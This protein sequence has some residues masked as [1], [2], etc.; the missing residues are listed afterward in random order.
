[1]EH[2]ENKP[3]DPFDAE[4]IP[5]LEDYHVNVMVGDKQTVFGLKA[6][7]PAVAIAQVTLLAAWSLATGQMIAGF[8]ITRPGGEV[9]AWVPVMSF[10]AEAAPKLNLGGKLVVPA[11]VM[12]GKDSE[13]DFKKLLEEQRRQRGP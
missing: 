8:T 10:I 7:S 1:M 2:P 9:V 3:A 13:R 11:A 5:P 4:G 12:K 6:Q